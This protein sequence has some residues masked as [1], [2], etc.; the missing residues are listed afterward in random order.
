MNVR[1]TLSSSK[2]DSSE[3]CSA[4]TGNRAGRGGSERKKEGYV[5][6]GGDF[7]FGPYV[8]DDNVDSLWTTIFVLGI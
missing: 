7:M 8:G 4:T 5:R 6:G 3:Q 2:G 1:W